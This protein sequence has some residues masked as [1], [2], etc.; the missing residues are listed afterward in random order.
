LKLT[1][2]NSGRVSGVMEWWSIGGQCLR[3]VR[4]TF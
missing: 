4:R 3:N 1:E 2:E